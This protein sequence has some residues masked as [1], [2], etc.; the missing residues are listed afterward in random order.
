MTTIDDYV[1]ALKRELR[2]QPGWIRRREATGLREHLDELPS[3]A[4]GQLQAPDLYAREYR[5]QLDL[6]TRRLDGWRRAS[7]P[8]RI[9]I[10]AFVIALVAVV[11]IPPAIAHYQPVSIN[12]YFGGPDN[13]PSHQDHDATVYSFREGG[14]IKLGMDIRNSGRFAATITSL[15]DAGELGPFRPTAARQTARA[16]VDSRYA[17]PRGRPAPSR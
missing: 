5:T 1:G 13:V 15:E 16:R 17:F 2:D 10:I 7:W 4:I 12:V 3:E 14:T 6:R 8:R 9:S 11:V